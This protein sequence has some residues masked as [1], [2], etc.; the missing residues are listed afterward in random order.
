M[1]TFGSSVPQSSTSP[2]AGYDVSSEAAKRRD[3]SGLLR[4]AQTE[5]VHFHG[6][7]EDVVQAV[8]ASSVKHSSAL[9]LSLTYLS[10]CVFACATSLPQT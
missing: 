5:L 3:F 8:T 9:S 7:L 6:E 10:H 2:S 1:A 4:P